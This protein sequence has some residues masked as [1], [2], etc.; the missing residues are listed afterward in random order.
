[1][2]STDKIKIP[3]LILSTMETIGSNLCFPLA[4]ITENIQ[5]SVLIETILNVPVHPHPL[6]VWVALLIGSHDQLLIFDIK[7]EVARFIPDCSRGRV[8]IPDLRVLSIGV[9]WRH[10]R[11]GLEATTFRLQNKTGHLALDQVARLHVEAFLLLYLLE[12]EH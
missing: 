7:A 11:V 2:V 12:L 1:M 6:L 8:V 10:S 3:A 5:R 4:T 9:R